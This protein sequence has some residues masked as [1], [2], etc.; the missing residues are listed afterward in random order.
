MTCPYSGNLA[1]AIKPLIDRV[2]GVRWRSLTDR[3]RRDAHFADA[4][5]SNDD[6]AQV[7]AQ[8]VFRVLN[9]MQPQT[10]SASSS[11]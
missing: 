4:L 5:H 7:I 9:G 2:F 3:S 10:D 8:E 1:G 6:R 11:R